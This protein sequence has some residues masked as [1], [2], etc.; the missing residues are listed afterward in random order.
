MIDLRTV[1]AFGVECGLA[2]ASF[3]S[4]A[5][6]LLAGIY[7]TELLFFPPSATKDK[8]PD[9]TGGFDRNVLVAIALLMLI[10]LVLHLIPRRAASPLSRRAYWVA[11]AVVL[12]MWVA[13]ILLRLPL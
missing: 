2:L 13:A 3:L 12:L 11:Y 5:A 10:S 1:R 7:A 4:W 8:V 6:L 9:F